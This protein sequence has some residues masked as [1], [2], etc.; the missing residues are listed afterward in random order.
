MLASFHTSTITSNQ[1]ERKTMKALRYTQYGSS[2]VLRIQEVEKPT[3]KDNEVLIR[4]IAAGV[5]PADW[6]LM[7]AKPFLARLD[8][9]LRRP[10]NPKLG[11]DVA[12]VVD[13][14]GSEVTAF[15]PGDEVFADL[16]DAGMGAFA[17]YAVV[18]DSFVVQKPANVTF[19][20]A[21]GVPLAGVTALQGLR[22]GE[23]SA[24]KTVLVNGASGGVGT[25]A[26]QIAKSFGATVTGV[27]STRNQE[28]VRGIGADHVM[29]YTREDF[30]NNGKKYDL[31]YDAIGNRSVSDLKRALNPTGQAVVAGFTSMPLLFQHMIIGPL[32]S[33]KNQKV[34]QQGT[35]TPNRQD[36][37]YLKMLLE[38][39]K[40]VTVID[41]CYPF[42]EIAQ[43]ISYVETGRARGK[44]IITIAS[45]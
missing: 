17:E 24:G 44:V 6:R 1:N 34:G 40:M 20:Q 39:E 30:T 38:T 45:S 35:A 36:L 7:R 28:L 8:N 22:K 11:S 10:K 3:P 18:A 14:V 27:C 41:R 21:A 2:D 15:K 31:I 4:V 42:S 13:A 16:F 33:N 32:R 9:G 43:A 12:G 23:I 19:E 25:F 26:V 5:N 37:E 29:D